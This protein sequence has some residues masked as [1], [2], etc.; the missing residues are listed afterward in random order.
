MAKTL[1]GCDAS[2]VTIGGDLFDLV[3]KSYACF[4]TRPTKNLKNNKQPSSFNNYAT[5][6]AW[7]SAV[8]FFIE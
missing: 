4:P 8:C 1:L 3:S 2:R 6:T 7:S 5:A